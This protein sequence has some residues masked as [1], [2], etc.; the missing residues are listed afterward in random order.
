MACW[1]ERTRCK[2]PT[3]YPVVP[4]QTPG[5][6]I[7]DGESNNHPEP[8]T[9]PTLESPHGI[10]VTG[11]PCRAH[12]QRTEEYPAARCTEKEAEIQQLK[13]KLEGLGQGTSAGEGEQAI[14]V[15]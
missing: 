11:R 13:S 8:D 4:G 10:D 6:V 2:T 5:E 7:A 3:Y 9:P 1:P 15:K 14:A 12:S